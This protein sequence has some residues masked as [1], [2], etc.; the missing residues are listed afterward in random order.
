MR[1]FARP[2]SPHPT[3]PPGSR[4]LPSRTAKTIIPTTNT[5][6]W[7]LNIAF[8]SCVEF[9]AE[10]RPAETRIPHKLSSRITATVVDESQSRTDAIRR[11][12]SLVEEATARGNLFLAFEARLP[13]AEIEIRAGQRE[14]GR[15][16]LASLEKDAA[17]RGFG[18]IA[19]KA[20]AAL[21]ASSRAE[22]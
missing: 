15:S 10:T 12:R 17:A 1:G 5:H 11:L 14:I 8:S 22:R 7:G 2:D 3:N 19:R 20:R 16:H 9:T 4:H 18:L 6:R 21:D 13:L